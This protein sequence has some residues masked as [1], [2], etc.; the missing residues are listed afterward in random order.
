MICRLYAQSGQ[1]VDVLNSDWTPHFGAIYTWVAVD[2]N[3]RVAV[4]V[5][6][7][8][9]DIPEVLLKE[10]SIEQRL[11]DVSDFLWEGGS[12][13]RSGGCDLQG[14]SVDMFSSWRRGRFQSGREVERHLLNDFRDAGRYAEASLAI[15][16]G[17]FV[18]H[19][20]EG[21][22]AGADYPVGYAGAVE[23]GD[24]FRYLVPGAPAAV[25]DFPERVRRYFVVSDSVDF[26][27]D[28]L[29]ASASIRGLFNRMYV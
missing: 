21:D 5:N 11:D 20:L 15:N 3:G 1:G 6:N 2:V 26:K 22:I 18:Y 14:F 7:C 16:F 29:I 28:G 19:G 9:G 12:V 10:D 4:M 25:I 8:F 17:A 27:K 23:M 24:Y 13:G